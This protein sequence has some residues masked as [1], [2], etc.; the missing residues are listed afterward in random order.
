MSKAQ[1]LGVILILMGTLLIL[2]H[3]YITGGRFFDP[4]DIFH[5]EFFEALFITVG[6]ILLV[7][8]YFK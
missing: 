4:Q 3:M 2:H 6:L 5:H 8:S 1:K 7:N